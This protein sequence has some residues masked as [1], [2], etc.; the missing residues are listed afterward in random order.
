MGFFLE[1]VAP[2]EVDTP[3]VGENPVGLEHIQLEM[4]QKWAG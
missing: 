2:S 1:M 4:E 3:Q